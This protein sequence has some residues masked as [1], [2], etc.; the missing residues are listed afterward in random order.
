MRIKSM[1]LKHRF[2]SYSGSV[3]GGDSIV[4]NDDDGAAAAAT[5]SST[6]NVGGNGPRSRSIWFFKVYTIIYT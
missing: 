5:T 6:S 1:N 4:S 2:L 3:C